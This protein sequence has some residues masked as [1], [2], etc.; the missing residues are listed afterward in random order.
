MSNGTVTISSHH[1]GEPDDADFALII[2]FEPNSARPQRVFQAADGM[3]R[4][5]QRLDHSL[6]ISVDT[7]IEPIMMLE[8]IES[9]SI[10]IWLK[11]AL[12]ATDDQA[13]KDL[14]WRSVIGK[15]L[16]RA[17]YAYINWSNKEGGSLIDLA[18]NL[19]NIASET[20]VKHLPDYAPPSV[21]ELAE[22][23]KEI[24]QAKSHL[25]EFDKITYQARGE[26]PVDFNLSVHWTSQELS[27]FSIKERKT[28][29]NMEMNLIVKRPDYLGN[30]KW[31]FRHGKIPISAKI[32]HADWL[33]EFQARNVDV[34]PGDALK[35]LVTIEHDYGHDNELIDV[36]HTITE[37]QKVIWN[38]ASQGDI[39]DDYS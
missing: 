3:I 23:A 28:F 37:V 26:K 36:K 32:E 21:Q 17:K 18:K 14:D 38:Q 15:Y 11:S 1:P 10:K 30:A 29:H 16:V 19:K 39:F 24:D 9:G 27:D 12:E 4:A 31:E 35:C 7:H 13:L 8:E 6:C 25:T 22:T 2:D 20:D 5:L 33:K 34:R